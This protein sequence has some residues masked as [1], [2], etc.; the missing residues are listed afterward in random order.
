MGELL[1]GWFFFAFLVGLL[2]SSKGRNSIGWLVLAAIVS[3]LIAG[4]ILLV[5]PNLRHER[6]MRSIA[7]QA[8][9]EPPPLRRKLRHLSALGGRS[10]RVTLD[11]DDDTPFQPDGL[12]AGIPYR[13][14]GR[15][16]V[17]A[18]MQGKIVR[19]LTMERFVEVLGGQSSKA[20]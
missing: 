1:F 12:Y 10:T 5:L 13:V 8:R 16:T 15:G 20:P 7:G 14:T 9:A 11:R 3:P 2:A 18:V 19:F 17:E 6:L 4:L